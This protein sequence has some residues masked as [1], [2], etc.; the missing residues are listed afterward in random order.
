MY[1]GFIESYDSTNNLNA[2]GQDERK[3]E[4]KVSIKVLGYITGN[5]NSNQETPKVIKK[6]TIIEVKLPR[7]RAILDDEIAWLKKNNKYRG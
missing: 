3:F 7:E 4:T 6:E 2:L 5:G 1:E